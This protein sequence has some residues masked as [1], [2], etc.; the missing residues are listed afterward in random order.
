ME[1][2][3]TVVADDL[4]P[5]PGRSA[6]ARIAVELKDGCACMMLGDD[7]VASVVFFDNRE[8]YSR[9]EG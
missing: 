8:M 2:V 5:E 6:T 1:A 9:Q 4:E 7:D 3:Q